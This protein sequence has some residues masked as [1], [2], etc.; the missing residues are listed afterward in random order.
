MIDRVSEHSQGGP[1]NTLAGRCLSSG[2]L[3]YSS[4]LIHSSKE[5]DLGKSIPSVSRAEKI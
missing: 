3:V 5:A 4:Y 1:E 2:Y